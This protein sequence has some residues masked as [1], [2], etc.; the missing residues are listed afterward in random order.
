M[1]V[2]LGE[3]V[4]SFST[5]ST[6]NASVDDNRSSTLLQLRI[7]QSKMNTFRKV[8]SKVNSLYMYVGRTFSS[9]CPVMHG[10][11][12]IPGGERK[13]SRPSI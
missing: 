5:L 10:A 12:G 4:R 3:R 1:T 2:P 8:N 11:T 7:K 6:Q 9:L 13:H